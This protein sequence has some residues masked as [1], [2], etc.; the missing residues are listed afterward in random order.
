MVLEMSTNNNRQTAATSARQLTDDKNKKQQTSNKQLRSGQDTTNKSYDVNAMANG[1]DAN[2][3]L[4]FPKF[5]E[6]SCRVILHGVFTL[7]CYYEVNQII[8]FDACAAL[9]FCLGSLNS[10]YSVL[11]RSYSQLS[12][13]LSEPKFQGW[14]YSTIVKKH[15]KR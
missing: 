14:V 2:L 3:Q 9:S 13:C 7:V 4:D 6:A 5:M 1:G 8:S 15:L 12:G 11:W 10:A